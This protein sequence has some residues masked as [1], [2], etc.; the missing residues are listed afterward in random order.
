M[1]PE[2]QARVNARVEAHR[3]FM[4]PEEP[5]YFGTIDAA[6]LVADL[7]GA[8]VAARVREGPYSS[9]LTVVELLGAPYEAEGFC[10]ELRE[11]E[12][13]VV[14]DLSIYEEMPEDYE[15]RMEMV[16][17]FLELQLVKI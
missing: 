12:S 17:E 1:S 14:A 3:A 8:G 15:Q 2:A 10:I 16:Q 13:T 5:A 6:R 4:E 11:G 9:E 7:N